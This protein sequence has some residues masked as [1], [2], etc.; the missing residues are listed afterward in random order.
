MLPRLLPRVHRCVDGHQA[1]LPLV[2]GDLRYSRCLASCG[3]VCGG[4]RDRAGRAYTTE[5]SDAG[6]SQCSRHSCSCACAP[7]AAAA[8]RPRPPV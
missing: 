3:V 6:L 2:Q 7:G 1:R 4:A 5:A 8:L